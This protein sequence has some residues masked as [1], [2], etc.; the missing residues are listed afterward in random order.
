[1]RLASLSLLTLSLSGCGS[2]DVVCDVRDF[3]EQELAETQEGE[4]EVAPGS[5][6]R[7]TF[8]V[9]VSGLSA[10]GA[11]LRKGST[12]S[13]HSTLS[14]PEDQPQSSD[15]PT[16]ETKIFSESDATGSDE[17]GWRNATARLFH[18]DPL[19]EEECCPGDSDTCSEE[20]SIEFRRSESLYPAVVADWRAS[21]TVE[22]ALQISIEEVSP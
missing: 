17:D 7:R 5:T 8:R 21:V 4:T 11:T 20:F 10:L 1:V 3:D 12:V 13:L 9:T 2:A 18:C 16:I 15:F 14:Y 22:K 6:V 19:D